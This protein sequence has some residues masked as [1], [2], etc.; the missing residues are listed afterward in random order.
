[1]AVKYTPLNLP[2]D[3]VREMKRLRMSYIAVHHKD[4]SYNKLMIRMMHMY[5]KN[6][7][8]NDREWYDMDNRMLVEENENEKNP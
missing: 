4:I 2:E 5:R 7:L 3:T 1:M 6:L 8:K